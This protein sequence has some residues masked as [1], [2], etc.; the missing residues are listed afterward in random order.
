MIITKFVNV[1]AATGLDYLHN[2]V[3][4]NQSIIHRDV[5]SANILIDGNWVAK[6]SD[7]GLSKLS[8]AG[9]DR[10]DVVSTPCGTYGYLEPEYLRTGVVKKESDVYSFGMV[11]FEVICGRLCTVKDKDGMNLLT[12]V[13]AKRHYKNNTLDEIIS[14]ESSSSGESQGSS[15]KSYLRKES[16]S[17]S[18]NHS[19][20]KFQKELR[21][22]EVLLNDQQLDLN[23][24]N[25][26]NKEELVAPINAINSDDRC[27]EVGNLI[28]ERA[29]N[30][31][32]INPSVRYEEVEKFVFN[33]V[34]LNH[35]PLGLNIDD[36]LNREEQWAPIIA[37]NSDVRNEEGENLTE[38]RAATIV[39]INPS[40]RYEEEENF[41]SNE[42]LNHQPLG[43]NIDDDLNIKELG[44]PIIAINSDVR[45]EEVK[46]LTSEEV[47]KNHQHQFD[48]NDEGGLNREEFVATDIDVQFKKE[49]NFDPIHD[50]LRLFGDGVL[51]L[52]L[53]FP[54][55]RE[56]FVA[57]D[58][59]VQF[60]KEEN[61]DP[62]D[63]F[64]RLFDD[65]V[66]D[67]DLAFPEVR[68][69]IGNVQKFGGHA[70]VANHVSNGA[71]P[72]F[73]WRTLSHVE[74]AL[75]IFPIVGK[76]IESSS[77]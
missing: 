27:E 2:H 24:D 51:D 33:E 14:H 17:S 48:L 4:K 31:V 7:L 32:A 11:L 1:G 56:E 62:I 65:G 9:L 54:E 53:A 64:L 73:A 13:M 63:D 12:S 42:L 55:V 44:A 37:I 34:L 60:K 36:D 49:E 18:S 75:A 70:Y 3:G 40:V 6:V 52:D 16:Q 61:F 67:L 8:L 74:E 38:E 5:K 28:E 23:I 20:M 22:K 68:G 43:L 30:I 19:K 57:T 35:Q 41:I 29:A 58:I 15:S 21:S 66:L 72:V 71:C 47:L 69:M 25:D 10:S 76:L 50:F 46:N 39:A 45:Y 77:I 26:L 59:D